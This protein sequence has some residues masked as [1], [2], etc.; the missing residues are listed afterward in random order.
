MTEKVDLKD[1]IL[2]LPRQG[3]LK[4]IAMGMN[5]LTIWG[6]SQYDAPD[7]LRVLRT[8]N[9]AMHRLS[10]HLRDLCDQDE[11]CT[12]S[13]AEGIVGNLAVLP[14]GSLKRLYEFT[15]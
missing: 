14:D 2:A 3:L 8:I 1:K 15:T 9:E 7:E 6:R 10:G 12:N 4:L 13:R 11:P 5:D